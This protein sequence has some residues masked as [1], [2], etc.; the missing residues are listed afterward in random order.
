MIKIDRLACPT[1]LTQEVKDA[2][3]EKFKNDGS[4]VWKEDYIKTRL[5]EMSHDKCCYCECN[6]TE[7]GS[8]MEIEHF[9][10][11]GQYPDEVVEWNN[12]L[13]SCKKC[14]IQKGEHDTVG[15]PIINPSIDMPQDHLKIR[16]GFRFYGKD[17]MGEE[18]IE[19]LDLNNQIK[20]TSPRHEVIN[21]IENKIGML[22]SQA[23]DYLSLV[24]KTSLKKNKL[25]RG[26]RELLEICQPTE[27]YSA[28]KATALLTND[29][30]SDLKDLL[31]SENLWSQEFID[32][33][34]N[35]Q[36]IKYETC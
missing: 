23:E 24:Q 12:L 29:C 34:R 25:L 36:S 22:K 33:E 16:M 30:Y 13:P 8:Y 2:K 7:G 17:D 28:F 4:S 11:K 10:P 14:N 19:A 32:L 35:L 3:T 27:P 18:T 31:N 5:L 26:V 21:E 6:V 9:H 20:H 1:E 15:S